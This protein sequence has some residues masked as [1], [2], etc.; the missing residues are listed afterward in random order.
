M[1][2]KLIGAAVGRRMAGE[3]SKGRGEL[4]GFVA[5]ALV[6]RASKPVL[7]L[8]G[9][10]WAAKKLWDWRRDRRRAAA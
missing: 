9:T 1:I 6:R 4:I 3:N 2:G 7:V 8:A 5:P 10:A